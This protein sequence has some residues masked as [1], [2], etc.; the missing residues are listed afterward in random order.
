MHFKAHASSLAASA[1]NAMRHVKAHASSLAASAV[2]AVRYFE[3][4]IPKHAKDWTNPSCQAMGANPKHPDKA[5]CSPVWPSLLA[6]IW[7]CL[8][9]G[10][11]SRSQSFTRPSPGKLCEQGIR[12]RG[13]HC[14]APKAARLHGVGSWGADAP[15]FHETKLRKT[16]QLE[17][18]GD[19]DHRIPANVKTKFYWFCNLK[20]GGMDIIAVSKTGQ[21]RASSQ[22]SWL[23]APPPR[24]ANLSIC[25]Q[26]RPPPLTQ[27]VPHFWRHILL[28]MSLPTRRC[29]KGEGYIAVPA[30]ESSSAEA[31]KCM[32][33]T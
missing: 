10:V 25:T 16:P 28:L 7:Q 17:A 11:S 19:I 13:Y 32:Q 6:C 18:S 14:P 22:A 9:A 12:G 8:W 31:K 27:L 21:A 4:L 30:Y 24:Y 15:F 29:R 3:S 23:F 2:N 20:T 26:N 5:A 33:P 1:V